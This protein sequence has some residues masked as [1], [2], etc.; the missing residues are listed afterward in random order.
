MDGVHDVAVK[1]FSAPSSAHD[2]EVLHT[3]IAVLRSCNSSNIVQFHGVC[4]KQD[5]VWIVMEL[6]QQGSL[7]NSLERSKRRCMW[8]HRC[9]SANSLVAAA[10]MYSY[11]YTPWLLYHGTGKVPVEA[12]LDNA[13]LHDS[14]P[15]ALK[16]CNI[17]MLVVVYPDILIMYPDTL[18]CHCCNWVPN[19]GVCCVSWT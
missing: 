17:G 2:M 15:N 12:C 14:K 8:Y 7:Y 19:I 3:E 9:P 16:T 18:I 10:P 4:T 11:S 5:N 1:V 13:C 6:L